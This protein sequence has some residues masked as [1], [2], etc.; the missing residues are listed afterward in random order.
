ME[1][2]AVRMVIRGLGVNLLLI[3]R[4]GFTSNGRFGSGTV[5]SSG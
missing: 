1:G 3:W 2:F 5:L 4:T